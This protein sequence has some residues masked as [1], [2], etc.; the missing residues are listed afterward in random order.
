MGTLRGEIDPQVRLG[1][2]YISQ[3]DI[4]KAIV[5]LRQALTQL[6]LDVNQ[7]DLY[8]RLNAL[9][10][11]AKLALQMKQSIHAVEL[12]GFVEGELVKG[13]HEIW[14]FDRNRH[15]QSKE[16]ARDALNENE[17]QEAWQD[18]FGMTMEQA[19]ALALEVMDR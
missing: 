7:K 1:D 19:L 18:G 8:L 17:F 11:S 2:H 9:T 15:G 5:C 4:P 13:P 3:H 14:A 12:L 16:K 6:T 10:V